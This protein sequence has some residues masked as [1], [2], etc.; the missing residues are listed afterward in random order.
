MANVTR[1]HSGVVPLVRLEREPACIREVSK[2]ATHCSR[3]LNL[4]SCSFLTS[5]AKTTSAGAVES[6]QEALIL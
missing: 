2:D 3:G 6:M 5:D 4:L 1:S